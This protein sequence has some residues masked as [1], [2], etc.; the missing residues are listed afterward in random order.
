MEYM[1]GRAFK[2][3]QKSEAYSITGKGL[4]AQSG[5]TRK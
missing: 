4:S 5:L 2:V 1:K 3:V